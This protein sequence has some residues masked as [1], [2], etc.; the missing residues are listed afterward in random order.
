M[1][2]ATV[3]GA[4]IGLIGNMMDDGGGQTVTN[5]VPA[6]F[7]GLASQ[8]GQYGQG[9]ADMPYSPYPYS[10]V[11]D[12]NPYQYMGMDMGAGYAMGNQLPQYAQDALQQTLGGEYLGYSPGTNPFMGMSTGTNPMIG[13]TTGTNPYMGQNPYLDTVIGNTLNDVTKQFNTSVAP[14]MAA[15]AMKSGSFGNTGFQEAENMQRDDLAKRLGSISSGMRMQDYGATQNLYENQLGRAQTQMGMN[16]GL[17][18]NQLNR[19]QTQLGMNQG[20]YEGQLNRAQS[21]FD[22]ERNRMM[23]ALGQA[24]NIYQLGYQPANYLQ[25]IGAT[26][27][28]QG[29]NVLNA[30]YG[31][32]QDAQNYPFKIWDAMRAP[33]GGV[34]AGGTQT[35]TQ[36]GSPLAGALGG[37]MLGNQFQNNWGSGFGGNSFGNWANTYGG[38]VNPFGGWEP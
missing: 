25:N 10:Q 6:E 15:T 23:G 19:A 16:Q 20:L 29:Q 28:Q 2:W 34:N 1:S 21:G 12:F 24:G 27:Q 36:Q 38:N 9:F 3:A 11:A 13:M 30:Q 14:S 33:F 18:E 4:G 7:S 8:V 26:M 32:Y 5:Q 31:Q 35:T 17:Y 22:A 37:A